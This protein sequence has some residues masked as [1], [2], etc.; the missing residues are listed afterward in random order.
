LDRGKNSK[1]YEYLLGGEKLKGTFKVVGSFENLVFI[2]CT[3][4]VRKKLFRKK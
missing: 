2:E 3:L 4:S 1:V